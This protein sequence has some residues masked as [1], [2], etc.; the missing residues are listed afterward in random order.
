MMLTGARAH[1]CAS[2]TLP[3]HPEIHGHS[4][5]VWAYTDNTTDAEVWQSQL[6]TVCA[7]L[8]HTMLNELFDEP[9]MEVIAMRIAEA[10]RAKSVCITRPLEGL[11]AEYTRDHDNPQEAA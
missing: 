3:E 10:M 6:K 2:H 5:E 7:K 4:Y 8:D 11:S 1:F 9:T